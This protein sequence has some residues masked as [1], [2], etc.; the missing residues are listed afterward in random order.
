MTTE[1]ETAVSNPFRKCG[2]DTVTL[3][4][5]TGICCQSLPK[6]MGIDTPLHGT[7]EDHF[8]LRCILSE[9]NSRTLALHQ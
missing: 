5:P 9:R 1:R 4:Y 2:N 7:S 3:Q 8:A 6:A